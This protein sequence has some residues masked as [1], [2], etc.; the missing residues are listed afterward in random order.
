MP[1]H[2]LDLASFITP[3]LVLCVAGVLA[4]CADPAPYQIVGPMAAV[5]PPQPDLCD[6]V[7]LNVLIGQD[8][9]RLADQPLVGT[10]RVIWPEQEI[11]SE[12]EPKRLNAQVSDQGLI[13]ALSCG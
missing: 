1:A 13:V 11:T 4:G 3:T 6:L 12:I 10:L 7:R 8:F 5:L 2:R 9:I